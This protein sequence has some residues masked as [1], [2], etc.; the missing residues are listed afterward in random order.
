MWTFHHRG[1]R[2]IMIPGQ[3]VPGTAAQWAV[4]PGRNDVHLF[5]LVAP[6]WAGPA[7]E[8]EENSV[9]K[10][11]SR[12]CSCWGALRARELRLESVPGSPREDKEARESSRVHEK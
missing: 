3:C 12:R 5:L 10:E 2:P 4:E 7:Q 1:T 9:H 6:S 11:R 8:E